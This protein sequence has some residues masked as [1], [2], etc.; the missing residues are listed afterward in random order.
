MSKDKL[1]DALGNLESQVMESWRSGWNSYWKL[2][3]DVARNPSSLPQAQREYLDYVSHTAPGEFLKVVQAGTLYYTAIAESGSELANQFLKRAS[4]GVDTKQNGSAPPGETRKPGA[5]VSEFAFHG[6]EGDMPG[7]QFLV[8]NRS[9]Q[10]VAIAFSVS[11]FSSET[12]DNAAVP[13]ELAP[14]SFSLDSHEEKVVTCRVTI[15]T[16]LPSGVEYCAQL[17][18]TGLPALNIRL[19][20]KSLGARV[21]PEITLDESGS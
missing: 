17:N 1:A 7:R 10:S 3:N 18:A 16:S 13:V 11:A 8:T 4:A 14:N 21:E 5:P 15:P 19:S 20:V 2:V 6:Y 12:G 9:P